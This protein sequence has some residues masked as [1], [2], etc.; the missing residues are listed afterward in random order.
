M[1]KLFI[2]F[3]FATILG[4]GGWELYQEA[5]NEPALSDIAVENVDAFATY[6]TCRWSDPEIYE[7]CDNGDDLACPCGG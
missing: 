2:T 6:A 1:K 5:Q 7:R 3:S 4:I